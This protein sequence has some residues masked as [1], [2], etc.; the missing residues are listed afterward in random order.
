MLTEIKCFIYIIKMFGNE[1]EITVSE[2][3][4]SSC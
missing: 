2:Q 4:M 1:G 3:K